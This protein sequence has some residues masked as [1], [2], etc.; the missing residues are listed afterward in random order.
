MNDIYDQVPPDYYQK[1]VA[2]NFFQKTWHTRKL[3]QVL[4]HIKAPHTVLDVGCASGWFL[5]QIKKKHPN[6]RC[7][8]IDIY[9]EGIVYGKKRYPSLYL[10]VADAHELPYKDESFDVAVCTEVLEHVEKPK[11]TILEIKRVL[12]PGGLLI[13][14]LDSGSVLFSVVWYLWKKTKGRVWNDSHLHSFTVEKLEK[15]LI[16]NG[17]KINAKQRFNAGMAMVFAAQKEK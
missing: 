8:G 5:Y 11:D 16:K 14:E 1:G 2:E 12:K 6:T 15:L 7:H 4:K 9:K 17:F 3:K 10:K 13:I